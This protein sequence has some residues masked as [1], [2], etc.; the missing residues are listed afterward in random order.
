MERNKTMIRLIWTVSV[1]TR[2][3]LRRYMPTNILL[4]AIRTRRR[5]LKWG[6]P[7]MLLAVP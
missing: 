2:Y 6:I 7:A 5:G 4:Y 1:H 3:F